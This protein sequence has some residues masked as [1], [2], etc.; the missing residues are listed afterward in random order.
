MTI[1]TSIPLQLFKKRKRNFLLLE[2]L[3]CLALICL[4]LSPLIESPL[5]AYKSSID[6]LEEI[7]KQNLATSSF[8]EIQLKLL[9][10]EISW[11]KIPTQGQSTELKLPDAKYFIGDIKEVTAERSFTLSCK[12]GQQK[13][14]SHD[15]TILLLN[16]NIKI[17]PKNNKSSVY[18]FKTLVKR[19]SNPENT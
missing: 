10:N 2:I 11:E 8:A 7:E 1:Y 4:C 9:N 16:I 17:S 18:K 3:I 13:I 12:K 15:E 19:L 6:H 5:Q 14:S